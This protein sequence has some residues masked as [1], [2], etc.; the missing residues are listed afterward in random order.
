MKQIYWLIFA[1]LFIVVL[2]IG[3]DYFTNDLRFVL[4]L[5]AGLSLGKWVS[6]NV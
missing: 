5:G 1:V 6:Y 3:S 2:V 4:I